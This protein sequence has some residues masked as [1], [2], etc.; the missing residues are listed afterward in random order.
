MNPVLYKNFGKTFAVVKEFISAIYGKPVDDLDGAGCMGFDRSN[1]EAK[2]SD[3][4]SSVFWPEPSFS[5][6]GFCLVLSE[7]DVPVELNGSTTHLKAGMLTLTDGY[8]KH[9]I[10]MDAFT[11]LYSPHLLSRNG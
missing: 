4:F 10:A 7:C 5:P 3:A 8:F 9:R 1:V 11:S 6:F 2:K